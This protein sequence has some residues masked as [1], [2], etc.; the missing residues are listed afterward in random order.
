MDTKVTKA[1]IVK[2]GGLYLC[3]KEKGAMTEYRANENEAILFTEE[4]HAKNEAKKHDKDYGIELV[5]M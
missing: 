2:S 3:E 5:S 4:I 1:F